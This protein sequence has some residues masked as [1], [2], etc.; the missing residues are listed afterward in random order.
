MPLRRLARVGEALSLSRAEFGR[1][2]VALAVAGVADHVRVT[3]LCAVT[4]AAAGVVSFALALEGIMVA[5]Y[6]CRV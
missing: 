3:H 5:L 4:E 6:G 1:R 2:D